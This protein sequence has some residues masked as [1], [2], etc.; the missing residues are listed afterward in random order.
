MYKARHILS[1]TARCVKKLS[2]KEFSEE[3][4]TKLIEE[5]SILRKLVAMS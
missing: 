5:V 2:K 3:D 4:R 1:K